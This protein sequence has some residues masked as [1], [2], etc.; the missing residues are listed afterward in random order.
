MP[1][2]SY[3]VAAE[4]I[5]GIFGWQCFLLAGSRLSHCRQQAA[6]AIVMPAT[7][8]EH[9]C[10]PRVAPG[11]VWLHARQIAGNKMLRNVSQTCRALNIC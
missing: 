5:S 9:K 4:S 1:A 11:S 3:R 8:S 10:R 6:V 2:S 7:Q